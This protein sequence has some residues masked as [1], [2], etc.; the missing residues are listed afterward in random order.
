LPGAPPE[1]PDPPEAPPAPEPLAAADTLTDYIKEMSVRDRNGRV[2]LG[3]RLSS[4]ASYETALAIAEYYSSGGQE[5][6]LLVTGNGFEVERFRV[7]TD[8]LPPPP[9]PPPPPTAPVPPPPPPTVSEADLQRYAT[10]LSDELAQ[11]EADFKAVPAEE[12]L[13]NSQRFIRARVRLE[14]VRAE[15]ER[16]IAEQER[17][18]LEALRSRALSNG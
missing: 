14:T 18:R 4:E 2:S 10:L 15:Y 6:R 1:A 16:L 13:E 3:L 8:V 11:A 17:R 7:R 5:G 9:P 12:Q